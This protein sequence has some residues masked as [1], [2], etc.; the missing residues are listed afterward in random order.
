MVGTMGTLD[1]QAKVTAHE[2]GHN[3]NAAHDDTGCNGS[4]RL[5]CPSIQATGSLEFSAFSANQ[6]RSH[7]ENTIG[8]LAEL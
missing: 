2:I 8:Y 1:R 7:A 6:I 5:M 3:F 4:G